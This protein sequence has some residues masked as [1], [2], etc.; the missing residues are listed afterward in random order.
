MVWAVLVYLGKVVTDGDRPMGI[1][2]WI[3]VVDN[4]GVDGE[5]CE[6]HAIIVW[7]Y[8]SR[9]RARKFDVV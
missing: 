6:A 1:D 3:S 5:S 4:M 7:S 9:N 2:R 8:M